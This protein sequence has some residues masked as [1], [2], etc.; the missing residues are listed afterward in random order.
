MTNRC[1]VSVSF[2]AVSTS[3]NGTARASIRRTPD[4][5]T[6]ASAGSSA[7]MSRVG[8]DPCPLPTICSRAARKAADGRAAVGPAIEPTSIQ[9]NGRSRSLRLVTMARIASA[10]GSP[11][12]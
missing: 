5:T 4:V 9:V 3:A 6:S 8:T 10:V 2:H 12:R 7:K 11:H 1:D